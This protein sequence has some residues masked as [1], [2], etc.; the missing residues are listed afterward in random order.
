MVASV[1]PRRHC[2]DEALEI[3]GRGMHGSEPLIAGSAFI[4]LSGRD[5]TQQQVLAQ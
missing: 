5:V 1:R 2:A 3:K 4:L